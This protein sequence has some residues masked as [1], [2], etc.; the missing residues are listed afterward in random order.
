MRR[1]IYDATMVYLVGAANEEAASVN[2]AAARLLLECIRISGSEDEFRARLR[3]SEQA[4]PQVAREAWHM[5]SEA[6]IRIS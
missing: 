2:R 6:G 3:A 5:A 4:M 1:R